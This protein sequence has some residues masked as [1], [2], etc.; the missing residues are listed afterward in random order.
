M[1]NIMLLVVI[2]IAC[3]VVDGSILWF[4]RKEKLPKQPYV[5]R[6]NIQL[7]VGPQGSPLPDM[8][9]P[10]TVKMPTF[11]Q[12]NTVNNRITENSTYAD[13]INRS[14]NPVLQYDRYTNAHETT[15][16]VNND[17]R[18]AQGQGY[19]GFYVRQGRGVVV[20]EPRI[21]KNDMKP[22]LPKNL[23]SYRYKTYVEGQQSWNDQPLYIMDEAIAYWNEGVLAVEDIQKGIHKQE[24][25]LISGCVDFSIYSMALAMAIEKGDPDYWNTNT[26]YRNF[27]LWYLKGAEETYKIGS[28]MK[29]LNKFEEQKKLVNALRTAPEAA[30]MRDFIN[31]YLD[32]VWLKD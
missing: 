26:Q 6:P 3:V 31:K 14:R 10:P 30:P 7:P 11:I 17:I 29:D 24:S 25:D 5:Q 27:L 18:N 1:K 20:K 13:I 12:V 19:N 2:I 4:Y 21:K 28:T 22:F 8:P 9:S 32:G 15:H 16:M 23:C